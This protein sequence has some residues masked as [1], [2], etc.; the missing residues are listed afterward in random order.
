[1]FSAPEKTAPELLLFDARASALKRI[2]VAGQ[3]VHEQAGEYFLMNGTNGLRFFLKSPQPLA[4]GEQVEVVGFPELGGASPVLREAIA[5]KTGMAPLPAAGHLT[6]AALLNADRDATLVSL[7][8]QL[9]GFRTNQTEQV[10]ELQ[11]GPRT[12]LARLGLDHGLM[13]PIPLGSRLRLTGV[14]AGQGGDRTVGRDI[15]SFELL[16]NSPDDIQ[17]LQ[18][19]AWWTI[20]RTLLVVGALAAVLLLA[21]AWIRALRR[22]VESQTKKL[23]IEIREHERTETQL[24]DEI[25][26]RKRMELEIERVHKELLQTSRQAGMAEVA[27]NVLHNVGN[28]LNSVN[29]S[30]SVV[31]DGVKQSKVSSLAK[32]AAL[33]NE[34]EHDLGAFLTTDPRGKQLPSFLAQL[35]EHFLEHQN[36]ALKELDSLRTNIEHIKEIVAMQQSYAQVSGVREIIN[37]NELVEDS[38]RMNADSLV[39]HRVEVVR[40][41]QDVPLINI[42]RHKVLQILVNLIRN[43]KYACDESGRE[44]KQM[45]VRVANGEGRIKISVVDNGV[46]IPPENMT[47]IFNHGFTTRKDGHGFGLHSGALAAKEMG[48]E[49]RA[50]SDGVGNGATFTLDLPVSPNEMNPSADSPASAS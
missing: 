42:D 27:I 17:V 41:Y 16:L 34:H 33:L 28:V 4:L 3:I 14:Y 32:V 31:T 23:K 2:K 44:D 39:H 49:L 9:A 35:A 7:E 5:R 12:Y 13:T 20:K 46:G 8:S 50:N 37:L 43:A 11:A 1:L 24:V 30:A 40:E 45:T 21:L 10:L 22:Q 6:E 29:V 19:P 36:G 15:D 48:G 26:E 38:L 25:E 47:R 18:R